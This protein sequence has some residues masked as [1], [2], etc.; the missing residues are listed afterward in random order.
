MLSEDYMVI[1]KELKKDSR[2][3]TRE[4]AKKIKSSPATV[5][6]KLHKLIKD[7]YI[8]QFTCEPNWKK[9]GKHTSAYVLVNVDY[10]Y[11]KRK[12]LS[13]DIIAERL[14]KHPFVFNC[15][16][17]T[18]RKDIILKVRVKDT[19][20][21]SEFINFLRNFEGVQMT[22]TLVVLHHTPN[23]DNPFDKPYFDRTT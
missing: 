11:V 16:T 9:L 7:G 13:Q 18:G 6:R 4:I 22:E 14:K 2:L 15:D 1:L 20:E 19:D 5:H 23:Y 12:K 21:L 17:L 10:P 8:K 3:S